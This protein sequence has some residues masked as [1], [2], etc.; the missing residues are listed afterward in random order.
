MGTSGSKGM[1]GVG[2][3][4]AAAA[5]GGAGIQDE[6]GVGGAGME[7]WHGG[8][9]LYVSLKM[10]NARIIGDL[11]PHV[12]GSEPIIG[13]WDPARA[14]AME[15]ELASMWEL[16]FVVPPDHETL[17][18]K[19]L[20][21]PKD[22]ETPCV[23]E[24]GPT[25]LLTGG[26]LEGDVRVANFRLN[27]DDE[28]LEFR[29]FNKADIVSPLE[30]AASWRVYKE[31]FQPSQVRGIPDVSI[32]VAPAHATEDGSGS[33]LELDL[34]HYVVPT[35]TAPPTEYAA[36]LAATPASL[37]QPGALWTNDM[38]LSDGIQSPSSASADF[39]DHSYHNKDIEASVADSS[40]KLQVCGM[41]ESKSVGTLI[42]LQKQDRQKGLYVDTGV[43]SPKLGKSFSA[44]ALASGLSFAST[45][46]MPEAAGAVAAAAVADRLHGSKEDRKL[47][48]V[49]VGLPARGKTFTA[50]KLTRYLR[51]LG[52]ETKHF[53][54]GKYRRLKHGANQ[55]ADFF[56][57]DNQQGIEARN[58]VAALAMEDMIDW[59]HGGGQVGIFDATNSTRKRRYM[60]MKMAEGNC[61]I[62]FLETICNDRNI[63]ERNVRLKIQQSPDYADQPDYE[64]GLQDF[65][66]RLTN[67]EKVYEPVEEGSYIKMIDMVK[68]QGGQL[69]V[70]NISGYL[71]GRIVFFLVNSHLAPRPI[72][73][74]RH[75]E[76]LHNVRGRVG[77]DTVLSENGE[78]YAK[79]L[80]NFIEKRLKSEKTATIW[81]STLQ[82]TILTAT[83]IVGFPKIQWRA[84]DE[85]NSGVCDGM[86]YEEIKK[87]MPEE[88]ESRKKDKLRYRYP[89]GESYLD[90][91]QRL[92][93]VIIELERQRAPVVVISHQ[94]V[95]RA[96]YSYF[97]DRPLRE[98]P[99][100]EMPLHTIIEIQMG[101]TGVEE[102]RYK[103]MD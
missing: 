5:A 15:R 31:N 62:I 40:K 21:K 20:L 18:F 44:C 82:R 64:A 65:L 35:P 66:E 9:Q 63:I 28:V 27:G 30:L 92:E 32:N 70:N 2:G 1:D 8:A 25:R 3:V 68:G 41:V 76:S 45:K 48:I 24:E 50:V 6:D 61:K 69:Q 46:A 86:T 81:T 4:G 57:A 47:A 52:H 56:R 97:A 83:P 103:L 90:V 99:D 91:I 59:M 72:L 98:V 7:S 78:L 88:Y 42:P 14:L 43:V 85:I 29:V 100:M 19:F 51:W 16:S 75:G 84:L 33:S 38:L 22:A 11:V 13:S 77:G 73:L 67:Y 54:V 34:E 49:L 102:K 37:I 93:P 94:A 79:K 10:E 60:L 71:P 87:I 53:N 101:V 89:R 26:M 95:L 80:A 12:Y 58:E 74:T 23:I 36:N 55:S 96:L 17:Y 39:R